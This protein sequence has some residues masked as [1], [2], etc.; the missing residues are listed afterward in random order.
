MNRLNSVFVCL[1]LLIN[2]ALVAA[3]N[4]DKA[5]ERA[6][7]ASPGSSAGPVASKVDNPPSTTAPAAAPNRVAVTVDGQG[8]NP[9]TVN[10][11]AGQPVR[12]EFTRTTDQTCGREVVFPTLNIRRDLPLNQAVAVDLTMPTSGTIAFTCGMN[13]FRGSVVVQ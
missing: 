10:A 9:S 3:C 5:D 4:K 13:M 6:P 12:L 7:V 11:S 2:G 8:Y 1:S